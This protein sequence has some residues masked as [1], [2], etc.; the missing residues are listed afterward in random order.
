MK[1]G[2]GK[3]SLL[4]F[5]RC[6]NLVLALSTSN[7]FPPP[8]ASCLRRVFGAPLSAGRSAGYEVFLGERIPF[9]T[10]L[11]SGTLLTIENADSGWLMFFAG[12][13]PGPRIAV[14]FTSYRM[15]GKLAQ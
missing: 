7:R 9:E 12:R 3:M 5:C 4:A 15:K 6:L 2:D 14:S 8:T 13:D 11:G 1:K 10:H